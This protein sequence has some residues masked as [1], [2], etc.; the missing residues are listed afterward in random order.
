MRLS[1]APMVGVAI[2]AGTA[3]LL[4]HKDQGPSV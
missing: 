1:I 4:L 2:H 3:G